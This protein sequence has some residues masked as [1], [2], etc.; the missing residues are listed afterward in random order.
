MPSLLIMAAGMG[1][2]YGGLK[3]LDPIGPSGETLMDYS[4]YDAIRAGFGRLIFVIRPDIEESFK[5]T[6]GSRYEGA[7]DIDYAFQTLD[8]KIGDFTIPDER[9]KPW[10]TGHA[11]L[12]ASDVAKRPFA[13]INADDY[14]GADSFRLMADFLNGP[15][16]RDPN[17]YAM[18]GYNLSNTLSENGHVS[19]GIC[20]TDSDGALRRVVEHTK[21]VKTD[22]GAE[23]L[24]PSGATKKL[25][26]EEIVSMNL[27]G[28]SPSIFKRLSNYFQT[29]LAEQGADPNAEFYI[30]FVVDDLI[31]SGQAKV[32]VVTT[33]DRWFG[34][35]YREDKPLAE[36]SIQALIDK[37]QYPGDLLRT[38]RSGG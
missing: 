32:N 21:I 9:K 12:V 17:R 4:I 26:G 36:A 23:A 20:E 1:S 22:A 14:Y 35:T 5:S 7:I 11:I 29:F 6:I 27:W 13:V 37:G 2:R 31:R 18:I 25:N 8:A 19:R 16:T 30:P 15:T 33:P 38:F 28:F 3:Q 34:V 24:T 10:G